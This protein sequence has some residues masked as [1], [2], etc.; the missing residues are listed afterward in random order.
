MDIKKLFK[1]F[2]FIIA[3]EIVG[4][5]GS[6]FTIP[7]IPIWYA[8]LVKPFFSPPNWVFGPVWTLLFLLMGI[9]LYIIWE[10]KEKK[11]LEKRFYALSWFKIQFAFNVIWSY[12]FFGLR[13]PFYGFIGIIFLWCSIV[14]TIIY[15]YKIN[16]KA[17][18]LL[19]PYLV[20]VSFATILNY[21]I[22]MLN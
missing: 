17:A 5:I 19:V 22:M 10:I 13:N 20:W 2:I 7:N 8:S 14:L 11:L 6:I 12:L 9:A 1:I 3:C 21:S 16:K 4:A 15:F 18:Y